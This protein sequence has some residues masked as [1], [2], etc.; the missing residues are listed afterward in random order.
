LPDT[1][2]VFAYTDFGFYGHPI[3]NR[4][5]A[6]V[7]VAYFVP[8]GMRQKTTALTS[9]DAFVEACLPELSQ[10]RSEEITDADKCWYDIVVDDH[11]ILGRLPAYNR[12]TIGTG[13]RGTGYK[14]AP[15]IGKCLSEVA[16]QNASI[17]DIKAFNPGRF[18]L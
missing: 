11:F 1:F 15:L 16:L 18:S 13:W 9:I 8:V 12:I 4:Q 3:F 7:K 14:F 2:P 6:A 17:Y 5:K 10:A